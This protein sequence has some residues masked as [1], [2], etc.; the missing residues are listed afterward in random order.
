VQ[1]I[2]DLLH[3]FFIHAL[4]KATPGCVL[5]VLLLF[6]SISLETPPKKSKPAVRALP[7]VILFSGK[8]MV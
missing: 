8:K 3:F 2:V 7:N 1:Q 5:P 4:N 6:T